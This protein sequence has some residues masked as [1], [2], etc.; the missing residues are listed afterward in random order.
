MY[1]IMYITKLCKQEVQV[2]Q[3]RK[4]IHVH[5]TGQGEARHRKYK[6]IKLGGGQPYDRSSDQNCVAT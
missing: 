1:T 3:R 2:I 5:N 4:N 6:R